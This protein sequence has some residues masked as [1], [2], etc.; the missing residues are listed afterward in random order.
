MIEMVTDRYVYLFVV[1]LLSIG[2]F[3][4]IVER[5]LVK[6]LVGLIVFQTGIFIFYIEGS[7][8]RGA[9]LPVIDPEVGS[10]PQAYV[11]PLPHLLILTALVVGVAV[12][13]VALSLI[14]TIQRAYGSLDDAQVSVS[15][16]S[17]AGDDEPIAGDGEAAERNPPSAHGRDE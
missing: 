16:T 12:L 15:R 8:A 1:A 13:G 4:V 3:T 7:V 10:D 2:F 5:H 9:D 11:N 14:V 6:K 17:S